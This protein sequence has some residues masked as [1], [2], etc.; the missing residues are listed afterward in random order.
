MV[1]LWSNRGSQSDSHSQTLVNAY[2]VGARCADLGSYV[3]KYPI[4][5]FLD[6]P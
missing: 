1:K 2:W 4:E 6:F 3:E 5:P